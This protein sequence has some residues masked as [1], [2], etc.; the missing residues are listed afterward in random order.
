MKNGVILKGLSQWIIFILAASL[1][2]PGLGHAAPAA[3]RLQSGED[4][5]PIEL[6][7]NGQAH[8]VVVTSVYA[9]ARTTAAAQTLAQYVR[10]ATGQLLPVMTTAAYEADPNL[11]NKVRIYVGTT[12]AG[13]DPD[14]LAKTSALDDDG[15][16]IFPYGSTVTIIGPTSWGTG[17]GVY[18]FLERYVGVRW[19]MPG[20]DGTDIPSLSVLSVPLGDIVQQ[21]AFQSRVFSPINEYGKSNYNVQIEWAKFNRMHYR[22]QFHHNLYKMFPPSVYG[23]SHPEYYPTV[24][25]DDSV[26]AGWQ[27]CLT[28]ATAT[29]AIAI[30]TAYFTNNPEATAYSLGVND[31]GG[32]CEENPKELYYHWVNQIVEGVLQVHPGKQFGVLAYQEV[33]QPPTFAL[34][35]NIIVYITRDRWNWVDPARKAADM[36]LHAAW[37]AVASRVGW[38]DYLNGNPYLLPRIYTHQMDETYKLSKQS[39]VAGHYAELYPNWGEGPKAWISSKLQW[40]P[41]LDAEQLANEWYERAVGTTSAPYL[42][43]YYDHWENF[44]TVRIKQSPFFQSPSSLRPDYVELVSTEEIED[45]RHWLEAAVAMAQTDKQ[46]ARATIILR[47]FEYFEA[48]VRS[49]PYPTDRPA[50][51]TEALALLESA[52]STFTERLLMGEKRLALLDE[53]KDDPVLIHMSNANSK[54]TLVWSGINLD[55]FWHLV[56]FMRHDEPSGGPVTNRTLDLSQGYDPSSREYAKLLLA[57]LAAPNRIENPSFEN[58]AEQAPPWSVYKTTGTRSFHRVEGTSLT[59]NASLLID[60]NGWG[61]PGQMVSGSGGFANM[62]VRYKTVSDVVYARD[63]IQLGL[64]LLDDNGNIIKSSSV[65]S[66]L[67]P[68]SAGV[69]TWATAYLNGEIPDKIGSVPVKKLL[70]IILVESDHPVEVYVDDVVLYNFPAA[71]GAGIVTG[72]VYGTGATPLAG[73]T[74]SVTSSGHHAVTD[75]QG[76]YAIADV[77]PGNHTVTVTQASYDP[78]VSSTFL[79]TKWGTSAVDVYMSDEIAPD[80][81][82]ALTG[83]APIGTKIKATSSENGMIYLV[84][85]GTAPT[86]TAIEAASTVTVGNTVYGTSTAVKASVTGAFNTASFSAGIYKAYAVDFAG[87]VSTG[88]PAIVLEN[89]PLGASLT[90]NSS[91]EQGSGSAASWSLSPNTTQTRNYQRVEGIAYSGT[92]SVHVTGTGYGGPAQTLDVSPGSYT[93][94]LRYNS[95]PGVSGNANIGI[96]IYLL[97]ASGKNVNSTAIKPVQLQLAPSTGI[98]NEGV[99]DVVIPETFP[100]TAIPVKKARLAALVYSLSPVEVYVDDIEWITR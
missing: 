97:D 41:D 45:S 56:D 25:K 29:E 16:G 60:G 42:K 67:F 40:N 1:L 71:T 72:S 3:N 92:A 8:A 39:G 7:A 12:G 54:S 52:S 34:N 70:P 88:S 84:P 63:V 80:L 91:F 66:D 78:V 13:G 22:D 96:G 9:D 44:W 21:P 33:K 38:Y 81:A 48:S 14:A 27:P 83:P 89:P 46:R 99:W 73:A 31:S 58:G 55:E 50:D 36:Q 6:V 19:L 32:Y 17:F 11:T 49:Y 65:R 18:E 23:T 69:S 93:V 20:T 5:S 98:W 64:N 10:Q 94:K 61:G 37:Q 87:N 74:V 51:Q 57:A 24:P 15:F 4:A 28:N 59:G 90:V 85:I 95:V 62:Q 86:L 2:G 68:L 35:P 75:A 43:T 76:H 53:F 30:I 26:G 79:L 100:G 82:V 47:A 77:P